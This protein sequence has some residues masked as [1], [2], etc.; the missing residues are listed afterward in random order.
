[1]H[2]R[3]SCGNAH[4][5]PPRLEHGSVGGNSDGMLLAHANAKCVPKRYKGKRV[6]DIQRVIQARDDIVSKEELKTGRR[7]LGFGRPSRG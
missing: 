5:F 4:A 7:H 2:A 1:M 6:G 3:T